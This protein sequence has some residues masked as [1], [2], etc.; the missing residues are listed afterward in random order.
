MDRLENGV[1]T[2]NNTVLN[3]VKDERQLYNLTCLLKGLKA[4]NRVLKIKESIVSGFIRFLNTVFSKEYTATENFIE[5]LKLVEDAGID[6]LESFYVSTPYEHWARFQ[7]LYTAIAEQKIKTHSTLELLDMNTL[8]KQLIE[9][10]FIVSTNEQKRIR[11]DN[12]TQETKNCKIV[13]F[14]VIK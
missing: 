14:K 3:E 11:I 8:K 12:F 10:E 1:I 13:R 2:V 9:E 4:L 5:L 7:L 6:N